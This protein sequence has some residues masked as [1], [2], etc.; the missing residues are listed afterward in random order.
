MH[1]ARRTTH[2]LG[3]PVHPMST[4]ELRGELRR[5][6]ASDRTHRIVTLNPEIAVAAHR[7]GRYA[8]IIRTADMVVV[9]GVG[10]RIA[11]RLRRRVQGDRITGTVLLE[12]ACAI[13]AEEGRPVTVLLRS[14]GLTA[15]PILRA[16]LKQRW[17]DLAIAIGVVD[18]ERPPDPALMRA[19]AEH[20]PALLIT[21]F[22]HPAQEEW[23]ATYVDQFPSVR[24]AFGVGGAIDYFSGTIPMPPP[25]VRKYGIEW[26]WRFL[27]QPWRFARIATAVIRFPLLVLRYR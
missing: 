26:L 2:L 9:D 13:A 11:L 7:N 16:A 4:V 12:T 10:I 25:L 24:V 17:P 21:N 6:F 20:T 18:P 22:G 3:I 27:R 23:I 5:A 14:D 8:A 15:P 19:V 1:R